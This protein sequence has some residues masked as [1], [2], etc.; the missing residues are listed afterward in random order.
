MAIEI[1]DAL[2][3][4]FIEFCNKYYP[5]KIRKD[6][7]FNGN[8]WFYIQVGNCFS[9]WIHCEFFKG[10]IELHLE[11]DTKKDNEIFSKILEEFIPSLKGK[12]KNYGYILIPQSNI[13][14]ENDL[15]KKMGQEINKIEESLEKFE[16]FIKK[17][18]FKE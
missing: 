12:N 9:D 10:N 8:N 15:L 16:L 7:R 4:K 13:K 5:T 3:E 17:Y 14:D 6:N 18:V 11:F 2:K 1:N